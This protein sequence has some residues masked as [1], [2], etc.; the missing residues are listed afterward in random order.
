MR[1]L[2][3]L[4][5]AC[6]ATLGGLVGIKGIENEQYY[7]LR[8]YVNPLETTELPYLPHPNRMG[9]Q[10]DLTQY[11]P[12]ALSEQ[13]QM[14]QGAGIRWIRQIVRWDRIEPIQ[15]D[16]QWEAYD[17]IFDALSN[18]PELTPIIV[19][20]GTPPWAQSSNLGVD[21]AFTPPIMAHFAT[22][23]REFVSRYGEQIQYY[24][25]WH[26][27]NLKSSWGD[28][29]PMV[30]DYVDLLSTGYRMIKG[31]DEDAVVAC[32][33]LAPTTE[34]G[35]YNISDWIYLE[36]LYQLGA[37]QYFDA[38]AG[39]AYGFSSSPLDRKVDEQTLNFSRFIGLREIM[40][41]HDDAKKAIWITDWGWNSLPS[42]WIGNPSI[43]GNVSENQQAHYTLQA[44]DRIE[45]EMP[46]VAF[47]TLNG[48]QPNLPQ[49]DPQWGF[50]LLTQESEKKNILNTLENNRSFVILPKDG[51]YHPISDFAQYSGVWTFGELGADIGWIGDSQAMFQFRGEDIGMLLRKGDYVGYIYPSI[52]GVPPKDLP[53]DINGQSYILLTDPTLQNTLTPITVST[54]L[55]PV[56]AHT[57]QFRT[58]R[59]WDRWSLAGFAVSSGDLNA[60]YEKLKRIGWIATTIAFLAILVTARSVAWDKLFIQLQD[61]V[62][63]LSGIL[64]FVIGIF[65]SLVLMV[66][67]F[68]LMMDGTLNLL[69]RTPVS[70]GVAFLTAGL[71]YIEPPIILSFICIALLWVLF[72]YHPE[73]AI[74]LIVLWIPFFLYPVQL[75]LYAFPM[76]EL[77]LLIA[78]SAWLAKY[79]VRSVQRFTIGQPILSVPYH[80]TSMDWLMF[81]WLVLG[82]LGWSNSIYRD[83]AT[84]NL[85][86]MMI[87]P[88]LFYILLRSTLTIP[89]KINHL[90]WSLIASAILTFCFSVGMLILGEGIITAEGATQRLAGIYGSP[91]NLALYI[92]RI[93]PF[94]VF[95]AILMNQRI[96][97][98][99]MWMVAILLVG[100]ISLTQSVGAIVLGLPSMFLF[101]LLLHYRRRSFL[102]IMIFVLVVIAG[103]AFLVQLPRFSKIVNL[104]EGTAFFRLRLWQ[105]SIQMIQDQPLKGLGLDQF[106]YAYR[107]TYILPDAWQEP[108][109]SHPHNIVLD[110]WL[111][112]GIAGVVYFIL[113]Q[114][115]YW[116]RFI[117]LAYVSKKF[118]PND[119]AL[120]L[121]GACAMVGLVSHGLVDNSIFVNDLAL[122]FVILLY[123]P[124]SQM[125]QDSIQ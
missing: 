53:H 35:P 77:L 46:Y 8:G 7:E 93:L 65:I 29:P 40:V 98:H 68:I 42:D 20:Y 57:L 18:T 122:V 33:T 83:I 86:T 90:L 76:A 50:S 56:N 95:Y 12:E 107:S 123:L 14:L 115:I 54:G 113:L 16:F 59:G 41:K 67:L 1:N 106:L 73:Q 64:T 15:G 55:S 96:L 21:T 125:F 27:P 70:L 48:W 17:I 101:G 87:E 13:L 97:R 85:R 37:D 52:D 81:G 28:Q 111:R 92:E 72:F 2:F 71:L 99:G 45:R 91:N 4:V 44:I 124:F 25:I 9:V 108:N 60:P 36:S 24:Q 5:I 31:L 110:I 80:F 88:I 49:N 38:V 34:Q 120:L 104:N 69:R 23:T 62:A 66:A 39:M 112:F 30:A 78:F 51:F 94:V 89:F 84:T 43:W 3:I 79:I 6:L 22:F 19:L 58:E 103:M 102:P 11:S 105:S 119:R 61:K 74:Y 63:S 117:K 116:K 26:E 100:V 109:L 32:A 75:Y 10:V 82:L 114:F 121:G 47:A 118:L